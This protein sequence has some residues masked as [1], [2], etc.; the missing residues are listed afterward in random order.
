MH[1]HYY[2]CEYGK[3]TPTQQE[4]LEKQIQELLSISPSEITYAKWK[5]F[6]SAPSMYKRWIFIDDL[7][8]YLQDFG[9]FIHSIDEIR[10]IVTKIIAT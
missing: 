10:A 9:E 1:S 8:E 4:I 7:K 3:N 2:I 6:L 5:E